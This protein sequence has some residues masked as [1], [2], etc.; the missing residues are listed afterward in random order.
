MLPIQTAVVGPGG[1]GGGALSVPSLLL[2]TN[3]LTIGVCHTACSC[4]PVYLYSPLLGLQCTEPY[5][6]WDKSSNKMRLVNAAINSQ[7]YILLM[8]LAYLNYLRTL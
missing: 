6:G 4:E 3:I 5:G 8:H 7:H 1:G 2:Y